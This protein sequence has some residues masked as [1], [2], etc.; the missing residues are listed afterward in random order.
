MNKKKKL[1]YLPQI[2]A[3]PSSLSIFEP[4]I[5]VNEVDLLVRPSQP[6]QFGIFDN[7]QVPLVGPADEQPG[8]SGAA[9]N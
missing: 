2:S 9:P 7:S 1:E 3:D 5:D 8:G 4:S 6:H